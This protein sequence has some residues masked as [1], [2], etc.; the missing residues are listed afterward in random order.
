MNY[1][2]KNLI[3]NILC[4]YKDTTPPPVQ[5]VEITYAGEPIIRIGGRKTFN[6]S[7]PVTFT[8]END[9]VLDG[10]LTLTIVSATQCKVAVASDQ[11]IVN[12]TFKVVATDG[13]GNIGK[14]EIEIT[15]GV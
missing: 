11:R 3:K 15:G 2:G 5:P 8:F 7:V 1:L 9:T 6:T 12:E 13:S 10:K 14:V 4:N